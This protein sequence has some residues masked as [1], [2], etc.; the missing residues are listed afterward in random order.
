MPINFKKPSNTGI[1]PLAPKAPKGVMQY[2]A[3]IGPG[4]GAPKP[5]AVKQ[6]SAPI[7]P[8]LNQPSGAQ[9]QYRSPIGPGVPNSG[10]APVAKPRVPQTGGSTGLG[11]SSTGSVAAFSAAPAM[12][13]AETAGPPQMSEEDFLAQD[14]EFNDTRAGA[15]RE[16]QN[17][18]SQLA[19]QRGEYELDN[20]N[21]L[22]NLGWRNNGWDQQDKLSGYGQAYQNQLGDFASRGMLDS[23]LY[24]GAL[25]DLNRGFNQ[26]R[27]D[28][29]GALQQFIQGQETDRTQADAARQS[30]ITTAQRQA[31]ARM[32]AGLN[33]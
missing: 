7:G 28:L 16:F 6:Y 8:G 18:V 14:A 33:L 27:D 29:G 31:I 1:G 13:G 15:E 20:N 2:S 22:R 17:L 3:P 10:G 11:T 23:S 30:A 21:T 12:A 5:A 26:Q 24:G 9:V 19:R 25:N 32:A 4:I